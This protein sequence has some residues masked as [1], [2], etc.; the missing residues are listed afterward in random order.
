MTHRPLQ[1]VPALLV[2]GLLAGTCVTALCQGGLGPEMYGISGSFGMGVPASTRQMGM[3]AMLSCLNDDQFSNPAFAAIQKLPDAS[4]RLNSTRFDHGPRL[5]SVM[6]SCSVP[7]QPNESG[8]QFIGLNLRSSGGATSLGPM[9]V[10]VSMADNA[11]I[12]D[13]G[14]RLGPRLTA[15][16]SIL[17][18]E[19]TGL[20]FVPP[21]GPAL[22][23][24]ADH[25]DLGARVGFSYEWF[26]GDFL[27]LVYSYSQETVDTSGLALPGASSQ[28]FHD[29]QW[30]LGASR[31]LTPQLVGAVE[32]Q[33][34][35]SWRSPY[36]SAENELHL[37]LE[38]R[39]EAS[40]AVRAG[41][42]D[43]HPTFGVGYRADRWRLDYAFLRDWNSRAASDLFGAS[44]TQSLQVIVNW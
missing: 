24:L 27:G 13:Y 5:T 16:L 38:Y 8:L 4:V 15:G 43:R 3:G 28:V 7:L 6:V 42:A 10:T 17:G 40:W 11:W 25:A 22:M 36:S 12:V 37:G 23:D 30:V 41:L 31:H 18:A 26:P 32:Y 34:G 33:R 35:T 19:N 44:D 1:I 29:N 9:P 20:H 21:V 2:C 14:R 39:P